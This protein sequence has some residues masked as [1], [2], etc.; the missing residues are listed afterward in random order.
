M[1]SLKIH[2]LDTTSNIDYVSDYVHTIVHQGINLGKAF[3]KTSLLH[4][5]CKHDDIYGFTLYL[6]VIKK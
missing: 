5:Y 3:F 2:A 6:F 1:R 4:L